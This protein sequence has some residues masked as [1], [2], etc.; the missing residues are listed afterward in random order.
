MLV[1]GL[2]DRTVGLVVNVGQLL[3]TLIGQIVSLVRIVAMDLSLVDLLVL[4]AALSLRLLIRNRLLASGRR[5]PRDVVVGSVLLQLGHQLLL[6]DQELLLLH[7]ELL[8]F[9]GLHLAA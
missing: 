5:L 8:L 6:R 1:V 4:G 2:R 7:L 9:L 3:K